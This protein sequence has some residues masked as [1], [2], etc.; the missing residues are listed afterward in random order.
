GKAPVT[1][2]ESVPAEALPPPDAAALAAEAELAAAC[3]GRLSRADADRL[4]YARDFWSLGLLFARHGRVPRPPDLVVWPST[5]DE[6]AAVIAVAR[7]RSLPVIPF[8]A[9][10]GLC[11]GTWAV[12]GGVA[13]DLK[14]LDRIAQVDETA[15]SVDVEAG[16]VG[17]VLERRLNAQG[18][19]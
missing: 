17:E 8:G 9:G 5:A 10:S 13:L 3:S 4:S 1:S 2:L 11:G 16:V 18:W 6:V 14:R 7:R 19:T 12:R 15:R